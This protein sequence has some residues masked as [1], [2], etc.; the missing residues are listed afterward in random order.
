MLGGAP[1]TPGLRLPPGGVDAPEVLHIVQSMAATW[2]I[3]ED[4]EVVGLCSHKRLPTPS[5]ETEIGYGIAESRRRLG[6]ATRAVAAMVAEASLD[7][8]VKL[9]SAA[10]ATSNPA[11]QRVLERNGFEEMGRLLDPEE[12][13]IIRWQRT[14]AL[15]PK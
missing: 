4:G 7:P 5:G 9:L 6:H 11:S 3:V 1:F 15:C 2:M 13:E 8:T 14:V 10:T 12:G